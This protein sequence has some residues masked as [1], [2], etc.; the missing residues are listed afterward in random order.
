MLV[1]SSEICMKMEK[2]EEWKRKDDEMKKIADENF[3]FNRKL[4]KELIE[5]NFQEK[6]L[7]IEQK[8]KEKEGDKVLIKEI[9]SKEEALNR[10]EKELKVL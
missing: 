2:N 10:F 6:K 7:K 1:R 8:A 9:I 5:A 4:N 3:Q